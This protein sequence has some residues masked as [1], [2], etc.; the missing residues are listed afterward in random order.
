MSKPKTNKK[1]QP[2]VKVEA[3]PI[4]EAPAQEVVQ[5]V[6]APVAEN[7][8][9]P[10][11][12]TADVKKVAAPKKTAPVKAKVVP[13]AAPVAEPAPAVEVASPA[14]VTEVEVTPAKTVKAKKPK[15]IRDSFTFPETDYAVIASLKLRAIAG[16]CEIK[17][18]EILRAGLVALQAMSDA[19]LLKALSA[20]ERIKTGRPSKN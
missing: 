12:T 4:V 5:A 16:G 3:T 6:V 2:D 9:A 13:Q 11:A 17:K 18:G 8:V 1:P 14:P 7:V 19:D 10:A 15:L 20:V